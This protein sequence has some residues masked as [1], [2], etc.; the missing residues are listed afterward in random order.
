MMAQPL[1]PTASGT[2][3]LNPSSTRG[4]FVESLPSLPSHHSPFCACNPGTCHTCSCLVLGHDL[5]SQQNK[6]KRMPRSIR[7]GLRG[8]T[9]RGAAASD[10][11]QADQRT[12]RTGFRNTGRKNMGPAP[13][14]WGATPES[15]ALTPIF[16]RHPGL[17]AMEGSR[18]NG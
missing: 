10:A 6:I 15:I 14:K 17:G 8:R 7:R 16:L 3:H 4:S 5:A 9:D 13:L 1:S 12:T 18:P 11:S 2:R